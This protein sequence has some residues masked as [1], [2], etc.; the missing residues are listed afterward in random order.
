MYVFLNSGSN[1][2][3][4]LECRFVNAA[5]QGLAPGVDSTDSI[6]FCRF[7]DPPGLISMIPSDPEAAEDGTTTPS[8]TPDNGRLEEEDPK[9][10]V[11]FPAPDI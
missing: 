3:F 1:L 8:T 7:G 11:I 4:Q 2:V 6:T 10:C 9:N 5:P